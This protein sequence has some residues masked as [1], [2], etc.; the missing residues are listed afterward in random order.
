MSE[1]V[2]DEKDLEILSILQ[3]DCDMPINDI[4]KKVNLSATPCWRRIKRMEDLNVILRRVAIVDGEKLD[5]GTTIFVHVRTHQ[6]NATWL[7]EFHKLVNEFDEITE[8]YRMGGEWDY[9]LKVVIKDLK[10]FDDFYKKLVS[11]VEFRDVTS[12]FAM[13]KMKYTTK[14]HV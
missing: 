1:V 11:K 5:R 10:Q 2:L 14:I 12:T 4:A 13:E 3:T 8:A 7:Q 9:L 6:H